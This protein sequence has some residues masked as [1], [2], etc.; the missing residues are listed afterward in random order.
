LKQKGNFSLKNML[1][2]FG[3]NFNKNEKSPEEQAAERMAQIYESA[4]R[5]IVDFYNTL[6]QNRQAAI[7]KEKEQ[8]LTFME[9]EKARRLEG[10]KSQAEKDTIERKYQK[11]REKIEREAFE[12]RKKLQRAQV[13]I[14]LALELASIAA[15]AAANP[16]NALTF[17]ASGIAQYAILS[18]MAIGRSIFQLSQINAQQFAGGGKVQPV[19]LG[20]GRI[21]VP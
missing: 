12:K 1:A 14:Q 10:A 9:S 20:A 8:R 16:T 18:A 13:K 11:E 21:R 7:D 15:Q 19:K 5:T 17:G 4:K 2:T 6:I 3:L